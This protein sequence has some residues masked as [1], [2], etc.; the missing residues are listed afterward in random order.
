M[1]YAQY[2]NTANYTS[3]NSELWAELKLAARLVRFT[4][5]LKKKGTKNSLPL[6]TL[7]EPLVF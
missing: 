6:C 4:W 5:K 1:L 3:E 7:F 2:S